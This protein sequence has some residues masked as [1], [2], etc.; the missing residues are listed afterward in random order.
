MTVKS[1]LVKFGSDTAAMEA[2]FKKADGLIQKHSEKFKKAGRA[3]AVAG[4]AIVGSVGL[5]VKSYVAAGDEVHKM[6]LRTSFSTEA[7]SELKYAAEISGATLADVEKGVKK[8]SKTIVDASD[9]LTTYVRAFDRIGLTAEELIELSP[10][11]QFDR[12]SQAIAR[13][14]S[15]TIRA[16]A[17]QDIFGRAGTKLLPLFAAGEEGLEAL[18]AKARE[19]GIVFDQE[20]ADKAAALNDSI[21]TLK[22]SFKGVT[23]AVAEQLTPIIKDLADKI[24]AIVVKV[25]AWMKQ[26]PKLAG[27]ITKVGLA[28]GILAAV[29]GPILVM[30]PALAAGFSILLGPVGLVAAAIAGLIALGVLIYKNWEPIKG[31]F[32][33]LWQTIT[34]AFV[35]AIDFIKGIVS[36]AFNHR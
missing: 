32:I 17:A 35:V 26:H 30:L 27:L 4:A 7:L 13:V 25:K 16:A 19:M 15:P 36:D 3:M 31:F 1:L 21:T 18:R 14:E 23:M 11:E 28:A 6:A 8:M 33:N 22:G 9:G 29:L 20:A 2:G 34:G 24:T 5:M 10:E 12:I